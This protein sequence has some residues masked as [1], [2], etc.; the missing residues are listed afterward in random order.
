MKNPREFASTAATVFCS[1]TDARFH[2][3]T[4]LV[5][6]QTLA[7]AWPLLRI[8]R[9]IHSFWFPEMLC[10]LAQYETRADISTA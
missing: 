7:F 8:T 10:D 1:H 5:T 4:V 3:I 9:Q 6:I 2:N